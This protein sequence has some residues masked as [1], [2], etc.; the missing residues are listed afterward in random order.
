[1]KI[2]CTGFCMLYS[3]ISFAQIRQLEVEP[4][5][6]TV[7]FQIPI[8]GFSVV[9]GKFTDYKIYM[10][11][12]DDQ[13]INSTIYAEIQAS[14]IKTGIPDRD[15]HLITED[16]F[17]T[18]KYPTILFE[19]DSMPQIDF[20]NFLA[21]GKLTMHGITGQVELPFQ[22]VKMDGNT[23]GFKSRTTVDRIPYGV[24]SGFKHTS[25]PDFLAREVQ[26]EIDFWTRKKKN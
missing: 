14:S 24:G 9:T 7:G 12:N 22:I 4:N 17:E 6:S 2:F 16:F 3:I 26:V 13:F 18:E 20:S 1:M 10:D 21:F 25:M 19:S 8:A 11:W 5:H 23:I 15:A